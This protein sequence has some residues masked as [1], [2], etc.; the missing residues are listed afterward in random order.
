MRET[1]VRC[2]RCHEV[3]SGIGDGGNGMV[4][5]CQDD[6]F[7]ETVEQYDL[8]YPCWDLLKEWIQLGPQKQK[9]VTP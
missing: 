1:V 5:D 8:C 9:A 2:D 4:L 7:G 3:L 6:K